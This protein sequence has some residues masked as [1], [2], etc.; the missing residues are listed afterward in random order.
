MSKK[1]KDGKIDNDVT[2][3]ETGRLK[4]EIAVSVKEGR[5]FQDFRGE[6]WAE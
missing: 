5:K 1:L 3:R 6:G 2:Q 4:K